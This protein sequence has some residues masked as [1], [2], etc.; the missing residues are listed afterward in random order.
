MSAT[1]KRRQIGEILIE[2][3]LINK[4]QLEDAL[5]RSKSQGLRLGEFLEKEGLLTEEQIVD[6]LCSQVSSLSRYDAKTMLPGKEL[7]ALLSF[8]E[9][10]ALKAVPLMLKKNLLFMAMLDPLNTNSVDKLEDITGLDIEPVICLRREFGDIYAAVYGQYTGLDTVSQNLG[11]TSDSKDGLELLQKNEEDISDTGSPNDAPVIRMVNAVIA[12]GVRENASDIH[13]TPCREDIQIRFRIDGLLRLVSHFQKAAG[14]SIVSRIKVLSGL[15]ISITRIPQDG[16]FTVR[17]DGREINIR[18]STLPTVHGEN[19][20]LRLLDMSTNRVYTLPQLGMSEHDCSMLETY[21]RRPYGMILSTGPTGSGK[22]T[23]LYSILR[24][25]SRSD[26]NTVTLEDPVE[27]RM[28][29]VRQVQLNTRAGMTFAS[30][31]RSILRQDPDVIMVGEIRDGETARIALQAALTGHLVLST[32]HTNDST[33]AISRLMDMGIEPYLVASV[34]LCSFAQRLVRT[35]CPYCTEEYTPSEAMLRL[36]GLS[37]TDGPFLHGKGCRH[38]GNTGF[39]GRIGIFEVMPIPPDIQDAI[40]H[41]KSMQVLRRMA[42][43]HGMISLGE[44]AR[45]KILA[46]K[47]T[48]EEAARVAIA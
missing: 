18:V 25:I 16:R 38:C 43:D 26:I 41:G 37:K 29:G 23:S 9:A 45:A 35:I 5:R 47:T 28:D 24:M 22:S 36:A 44:D 13:I 21:I 10:Q 19:V 14:P 6:A 1:K 40:S 33:G 8:R 48:V 7:A 2:E 20:V 15:D 17:V 4:N 30:G 32:L 12:Q 3:G 42:M 27:Y 39:S 31:L 11:N 46:G 34:L